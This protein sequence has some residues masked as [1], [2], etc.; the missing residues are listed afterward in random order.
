[1]IFE[2][3]SPHWIGIRFAS[4]ALP[5]TP[6]Q[7]RLLRPAILEALLE[8]APTSKAEFLE[9]IPDYLR[10]AAA[11]QY[12]DQVFEIINASLARAS[13]DPLPCAS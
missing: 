10:Q 9:M 8:Y 11:G 3:G 12:L 5:D 1:M 7:K 6:E 2:N 13:R 4:K